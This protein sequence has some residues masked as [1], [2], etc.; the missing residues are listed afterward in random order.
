MSGDRS[1]ILIV[2]PQT[3]KGL[4]LSRWPVK[5]TPSSTSSGSPSS[6]IIRIL[7]ANS[8]GEDD[9]SWGEDDTSWG[10]DDTSWGEDDT[11]WGEDDISR[12]KKTPPGPRRL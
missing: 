5:S 11:S 12:I 1:F 4:T 3:L 6:P 9:T 8:W 10:E 2:C 7:E